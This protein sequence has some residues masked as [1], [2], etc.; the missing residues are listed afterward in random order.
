[1]WKKI[2]IITVSLIVLL[3]LFNSVI[4]PWYVKHTNLVKV[5]NVVGMNFIDAKRVIDE[6]GLEVKQGDLRYDETKPIGQ[7]LEQ[8]PIADQFVKN[9]RRVY[10]IVCGGEQ[11][12]EVPRLISKT[13]RDAK[14]TLEQRNLKVGDVVKKFSA[15]Y[16]EDV[17]ISQ[18][19]QPGSKVKKSTKIDLIISNGVQLGSII[20]PDLIGK[21]LEDAKKILTDAKLKAGKITYLASDLPAGQVIDQYP[22]KDKS[23]TENASVELIISKKHI[24]VKKEPDE[25]I[26]YN[27]NGNNGNDTKIEKEKNT[28]KEP[29]KEKELKKEIKPEKESQKAPQNP[30]KEKN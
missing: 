5:P 10:L 2:L 26:N 21:K 25:E 8:V 24:E 7:V 19:I 23:A 18:V 17:V 22:K 27:D 30:G 6:T 4:M 28:E 15:E 29:K 16:P 3:L 20:I 9:G 1:M 14:F 13:L 11:L 12:V